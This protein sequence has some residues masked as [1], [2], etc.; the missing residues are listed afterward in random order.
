MRVTN[1]P[2]FIN[3]IGALSTGNF[4]RDIVTGVH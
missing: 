1:V 4:R 3:I 2:S